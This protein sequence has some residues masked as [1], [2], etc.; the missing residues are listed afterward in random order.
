VRLKFIGHGTSVHEVA[1]TA[2]G[3]MTAVLPQGAI[4]NSLAEL[5]GMDL[6]GLGLTLEKNTRATVVRCAV[7]KLLA[8]AGVL[9]VQRMVMDT[10]PVVINGEG[11]IHMDAE[12]LDLVIRG[13]PKSM[14][15][16]RLNA[17]VSIRG[18]LAHPSF[19]IEKGDSKLMLVDRGRGK[20]ADCAALVQ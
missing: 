11:S 14:R 2:D 7:A 17:P 12:T 20:D 8:H 6:R 5:A 4:R 15:V 19:G 10:E 1:A 13:E 3:T 9:S 16:L 18:T